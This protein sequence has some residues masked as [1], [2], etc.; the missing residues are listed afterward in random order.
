VAD[1]RYV[2][3]DFIYD[4][5]PE[6]KVEQGVTLETRVGELEEAL[7]MILSGVTE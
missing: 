6:E 5:V 1:Y 3:G 7:D 4:P 2:E